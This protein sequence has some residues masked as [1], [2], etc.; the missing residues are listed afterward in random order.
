M[1]AC[2]ACKSTYPQD[3]AVCPRDGTPLQEVG[4]WS[5]GTVVRGKYRI[6]SKVGEGGMGA[7]YKATHLRFNE[8]RALK[9]ISPALAS[10]LNFVRRFEKEAVVTRKLQHPNAVRVDDI[11]E[12]EDGRPFIVMEYIEGQNLKKAIQEQGT[13]PVPRVLALIKQVASALSAAHD[14]GMIHRDIKP[15]NIFLV[16]T[17][18]GEQAKV[19]DFGIAR[20][21]EVGAG[22][23]GGP[24]LTETGVIIG[25]P[26]YMSPEQAMGMKGNQLDCRSDLYSLG[27][28]MYQMLT[29]ALPLKA[30]T[31]MSM[32][33]AHIQSPP[34]PIHEARPGLLIPDSIASLVMR[35][36]EKKPESRPPSAR[37]VIEVIEQTEKE[38]GRLL[39]ATILA[40]PGA[41]VLS[42]AVTPPE[43]SP[44]T[45]LSQP[46]PATYE[47][48]PSRSQTPGTPLT[49]APTLAS[50]FTVPAATKSFGWRTWVVIGIV[51]IVLGG[52]GWG[53]YVSRRKQ[54]FEETHWL[55]HTLMQ[56]G[57]YDG[58]ISEFRN[59]LKLRPDLDELRLD[60][61]LA[62]E[63][64]GKLREAFEEFEVVCTRSPNLS[65][66]RDNYQK[67]IKELKIQ[68][69]RP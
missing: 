22:Q 69:P 13:L 44:A 58:A 43:I 19:L 5:E 16:H 54:A 9:V 63:K 65:E 39:G 20:I 53:T 48:Q 4:V 67:L 37:A 34:I 6:L 57:D 62:L 21:R 42:G 31:T 23:A 32:L 1:K 28:V 8:V 60:L 26:P 49:Q 2:P 36:L 61:A 29:G 68:T 66:C 18:G 15:E 45:G 46:R 12:A 47:P 41:A 51:L 30:D 50:G 7:V 10:D 38:D 55:G 52:L 59:A 14:L 64:K 25:S 24:T 17:P 35:L 56:Q 3:F 27:V 11:D 40:P 33:M